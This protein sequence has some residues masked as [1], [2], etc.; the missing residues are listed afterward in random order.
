MAFVQEAKGAS[1]AGGT[2][3]AK[4]YTS[5]NTAGNLLLV[6]VSGGGAGFPVSSVTDTRGNTWSQAG[7]VTDTGNDQACALWYA[8]N[9]AAGANTVTVNFAAS[10]AFH[11]V[12]IAEYDSIATTSPLDGS[13]TNFGSAGT[14]TDAI[15]SGNFTPTTNGDLIVGAVEDT[16]ETATITAGTNF[17]LRGTAQ[18][19]LNLEDLTQATAGAIAATFTRSNTGRFAVVGAAFKPAATAKAPPP[20]PPNRRYRHNLVR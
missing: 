20:V 7:T 18:N 16:D 8:P 1:D 3:I 13:S 4:A 19:G 10:C 17:T 12:K 9:C 5:N 15:S 2:S 6:A 14:A 11:R